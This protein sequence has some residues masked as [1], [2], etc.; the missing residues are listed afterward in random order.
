M[1]PKAMLGMD[2]FH[3]VQPAVKMTGDVRMRVA[4]ARYGR[5]RSG[6]PQYSVNRLLG[7]NVV[8]LSGAQFAKIIETLDQDRRGPDRRALRSH[9]PPD[10]NRPGRLAQA[11]EAVPGNRRAPS[12]A[13]PVSVS[14]SVSFTPGRGRSPATADRTSAQVTYA[15]GQR[16]MTLRIPRKRV[17]G[18]P[19]RGFKSHLHRR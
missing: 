15:P 14:V 12:L 10:G 19:L 7:G 2:L 1:L 3:V 18:Q 6:D 13:S 9:R 4:R 5:G 11:A 16:R 8:D 17:R